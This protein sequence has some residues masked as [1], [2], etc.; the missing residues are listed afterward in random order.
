MIKIPKEQVG[1]EATDNNCLAR[2]AWATIK[3]PGSQ[4]NESRTL[5]IPKC[6]SQSVLERI[7]KSGCIDGGSQKV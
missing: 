2:M 4:W 3:G 7:C 5:V 1:I 6:H